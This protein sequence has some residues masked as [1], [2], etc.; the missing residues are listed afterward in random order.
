MYADRRETFVNM[1]A[2]VLFKSQWNIEKHQFN[3]FNLGPRLVSMSP[4][5]LI[6]REPTQYIPVSLI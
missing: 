1:C 4:L 5:R 2:D 3:A 6:I